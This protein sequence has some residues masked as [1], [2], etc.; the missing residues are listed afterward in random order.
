[1]IIRKFILLLLISVIAFPASKPGDL[2]TDE[3]E[4]RRAVLLE[5]LRELDAVAI[6]HAAPVLE[7]NHD[8]EHPYRQDSD[9]YYLSS[10]I[11]PQSILVLAPREEGSE[12]P[13]VFLFVQ[14]RKPKME[15]WTGP[16]KGLDE[17]KALPG[18]E[19]AYSYAE[20]EKFLPKLVSGYNRLVVS[21]GNHSEFDSYVNS[22]LREIRGA[23]AIVQEAGSLIK[24]H[25]LIKSEKEIELLQKAIDITGSSLVETFKRIPNLNKEYEVQAEIEYGFKRQGS[26]RLGFPCIVGTGKNATYLHYEDKSGT[27]KDGDL[28]LMDVGAEWEFYSADISRTVPV[29]GKFSPEQALLYQLVLDAQKAAIETVKPGAAGREP[30][31][32]AVRVITEGLIDLGL[33]EGDIDALITEREYRKFFMHGTSH[34]LGLDVHDAG[35]YTNRDGEPHKLRPGMVL[36]VEPG[37]YISELEDVDPKWWNIGIRIEDD[38]LVTKDG[39]DILSK[40]IPKEISDIEALMGGN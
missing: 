33:L 25:R 38:V 29:S 20:Y 30:H 15:I 1:M 35:G 10:W 16:R 6:L 40:N 12:K 39:H 19:E 24:S 7:R 11:Y 36:T 34:W 17:A 27:L 8:V 2:P 31:N 28:I 13:E 23:P 3:F 9:F 18:I 4:R 26:E 5:E 21:T 37:I 14:P 22:T 32:T